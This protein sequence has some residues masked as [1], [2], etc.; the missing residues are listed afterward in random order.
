M[1]LTSATETK[2]AETPEE[3]RGLP[4][5][6]EYEQSEIRSAIS[7]AADVEKY[8]A[9]ALKAL[10]D[11]DYESVKG[12]LADIETSSASAASTITKMEEGLSRFEDW[13][14][15]WKQEALSLP[16]EVI[17]HLEKDWKSC[18]NQVT[19]IQADE[20][21]STKLADQKSDVSI[22]SW[23]IK[24]PELIA[25][26]LAVCKIRGEEL[27]QK[28]R[29]PQPVVAMETKIRTITGEQRRSFF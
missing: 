14:N 6:P 13:G 18:L 5:E 21:L 2:K 8:V 24:D 29:G 3:L 22:R 28:R 10:Q 1:G 9:K 11:E 19:E 26:I 17:E 15:S 23:G 4:A 27:R 12:Y 16:T 20:E 25:V 7:D